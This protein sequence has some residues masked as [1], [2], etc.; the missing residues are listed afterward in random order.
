[1][2]AGVVG[3]SCADAGTP[4]GDAR[5]DSVQAPELAQIRGAGCTS[6]EYATLATAH[7]EVV[8]TLL[9]ADQAYRANPSSPEAIESFGNASPQQV[10][11]V[12]KAFSDLLLT[13]SYEAFGWQPQFVCDLRPDCLYS[14]DRV[15]N[16]AFS[17]TPPTGPFVGICSRKLDA[18]LAQQGGPL[19]PRWDGIPTFWRDPFQILIHEY[20]HWLGFSDQKRLY[21]GAEPTAN[22]VDP[23]FIRIL[24]LFN[25][26]AASQNPESFALFARRHRYP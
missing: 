11:Y 17:L 13:L 4:E 15:H 19:P 24:G 22:Y 3:A 5:G 21:P 14:D 26:D 1:M 25:P 6:D 10:E 23:D 7:Q 18:D 20:W 9:R 16:E 2:L 8:D 12:K